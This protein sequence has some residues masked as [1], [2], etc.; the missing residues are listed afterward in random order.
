LLEGGL[1]LGW[2]R[3]WRRRSLKRRWA[4][5]HLVLWRLL[6]LLRRS[7]RRGEPSL[8]ALTCHDGAKDVI[9]DAD[10]RWLLRWAGMLRRAADGSRGSTSTGLGKF[11]AQMCDLFLVSARLYVSNEGSRGHLPVVTPRAGS[12]YFCLRV[13]CCCSIA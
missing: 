1:L 9:A 8:A 11:S 6:L 3:G 5:W 12:S 4:G 7:R 2:W 13:I 10:G